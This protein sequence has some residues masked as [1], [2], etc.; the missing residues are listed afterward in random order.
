MES[1]LN[2]YSMDRKML[3]KLFTYLKHE[4]QLLN[5]LISLAEKQQKALIRFDS[6]ELE[7]IATYLAEVAKTL[8]DAERYRINL[9]MSWLNISSAQARQIKL[10]AFEK[11]LKSDELNALRTMRLSLRDLI[12]KFHTMNAT[13]RALANRARNSVREILANLTNG[14]N[15]MCN[16]TI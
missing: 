1:K 5:E 15:N 16:V 8:R 12:I 9:L 2:G 14:S 13:N 6:A 11:L 4:Q 3:T 10:S 7:K